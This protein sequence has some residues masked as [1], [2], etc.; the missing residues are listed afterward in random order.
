MINNTYDIFSGSGV[1][2]SITTE[3]DPL[4]NYHDP[5]YVDIP[6]VLSYPT[7]ESTREIARYETYDSDTESILP[8]GKTYSDTEITIG[9]IPGDPVQEMLDTALETK[10]PLRFRMLFR[11]DTDTVQDI[12]PG[13]IGYYNIFDANVTSETISGEQESAVQ[14]TYQLSILDM[15][16]SGIARKGDPV[17]T[18]D[19]GIG[20]G[21]QHYPGVLDWKK[22]SGNR[23]VT[24]PGSTDQNPF[25]VD[26]GAV[27]VQGNDNQGWQ[28]IVNSSGKPLVRVRNLS[29]SPQAWTKIYTDADKP[30]PADLGA[31]DL[32]GGNLAVMTGSLYS[33]EVRGTTFRFCPVP[34]VANEADLPRYISTT[35]RAGE[36]VN[37][38]TMWHAGGKGFTEIDNINALVTLKDRGELVYSPLN[39][40]TPGTLGAVNKAGDTMSGILQVPASNGLQTV[41]NTHSSTGEVYRAT[42]SGESGYAMLW[43]RPSTPPTGKSFKSAEFIGINNNSA[44]LFRQ[45][46]TTAS[47]TSAKYRDWQVYHQGFRPTPEDINAIGINDVIDL[48]TF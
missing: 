30:A 38:A 44:L 13:Q 31:V 14:K 46:T 40:P 39:K 21:T 36:A 47:D 20:A 6:Q 22:L 16:E 24:F 33:P 37:I 4:V 9:V 43:R 35:N 17:L 2:I 42:V 29:P 7:I 34:G 11:I 41:N 18:G 45:D 8:G 10:E 48:G 19:W 28:L 3:L 25:G 15:Y 26:T 32:R 27:A 12:A 1:D 5:N 23:F